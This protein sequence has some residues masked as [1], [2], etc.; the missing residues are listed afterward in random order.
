MYTNKTIIITGASSGLGKDIA[1]AFLAQGANIVINARNE[2]R[3]ED[4]ANQHADIRSRIRIVAGDISSATTGNKLAQAALVHFGTIDVL[5]NNAGVFIP[6]PFLEATEEDLDMYLGTALKGSFFTS[7]AVIPAMIKQGG[8][9]IINIGSMWVEHPLEATPCSASQVAKGGVHTLTRHLAIEFA[10]N[11][12]R[13]NTI[14]P[15][16]IDTPLYDNLMPRNNLEALASLH[17]LRRLGHMN[18][19]TSWAL[20]IAG[21][22]GQFVTGQTFMVDGG[23]TAGSHAA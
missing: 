16:V 19:I 1:S 20:H 15:A 7:Q 9:S 8:G 3:L 2:R 10:A 13:V 4:F 5:V 12:I 14:A 6:K 22:G 11:N 18:D 21:E 23:I 17:P